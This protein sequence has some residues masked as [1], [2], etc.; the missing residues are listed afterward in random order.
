MASGCVPGT[1]QRAWWR[2]PRSAGTG[3]MSRGEWV[4]ASLGV[5]A[6]CAITGV[7]SCS[8]SARIDDL[9]T[10]LQTSVQDIRTD[11]RDLRND[12][13]DLRSDVDVLKGEVSRLRVDV[14]EMRGDMNE[15]QGDLD[16][17]NRSLVEH[18]TGH[19]HDPR[20]G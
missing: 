13:D 7:T 6:I 4:G 11:L 8:T 18:T 20:V 5:V 15:M 1:G 10:A 2:P 16:R 9:S 17:L 19:V 14:N 12:V 3:M